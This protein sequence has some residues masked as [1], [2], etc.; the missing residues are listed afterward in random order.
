MN[1][2]VCE[3]NLPISCSALIYGEKYAGIL[4]K[5]LNSLLIES[6]L[7][8]DNPDIDR[9]L[10]GHADLS[11]LHAGGERL[12]LAPYLK[13][14]GF[15][16]QLQSQGAVL[17]FPVSAQASNYP[18]DAQLNC[19]VAGQRLICNPK[20]AAHDIVDYLTNIDNKSLLPVRQG[21]SRCA[22]CMVDGESIITSDRGIA[23]AAEADGLQ[24]LLIHEGH[25]RLDGYAYGF[26]GGATFKLA[27]DKLA[28]TGQLDSHP[29]RDVITRFLAERGVE[30]VYLSREPIFD[31]GSAIPL[32]EN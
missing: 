25:I 32:F 23:S 22:V 26:I 18:W 15:A 9:R 2:F 21:Y 27:S 31:I 1:R 16:S 7:L 12:F 5:S 20:I 6:I 3:P 30:P 8:P 17:G 28:F 29:D 11:V 4:E 14:S 19:C 13:G 24:V 10:S